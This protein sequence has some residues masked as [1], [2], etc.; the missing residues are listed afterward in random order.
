MKALAVLCSNRMPKYKKNE[1]ETK[2]N[3]DIEKFNE[4]H[5][6]IKNNNE[7]ILAYF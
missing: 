6:R 3:A 2:Q 4:K 1:T 7:I 5:F